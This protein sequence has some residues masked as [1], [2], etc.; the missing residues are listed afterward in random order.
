MLVAQWEAGRQQVFKQTGLYSVL[1]KRL[2]VFL[3]KLSFGCTARGLLGKC[4]ARWMFVYMCRCRCDGDIG[5]GSAL[6][7][8]H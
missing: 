3:S 7:H 1:T 4:I 8:A 5:M 6:Q 2:F